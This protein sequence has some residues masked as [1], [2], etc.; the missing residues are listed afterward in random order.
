MVVIGEYHPDMANRS[1]LANFEESY[2]PH[3]S[4]LI[5][6]QIADIP[7]FIIKYMGQTPRHIEPRGRTGYAVHLN[8]PVLYSWVAACTRVQFI[9]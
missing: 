7:F 3:G 1:S 8:I 6:I 9:P 5:G 4:F 2:F